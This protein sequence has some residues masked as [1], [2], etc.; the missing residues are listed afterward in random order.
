MFE[1]SDLGR[2]SVSKCSELALHFVR[3]DTSPLHASSQSDADLRPVR[4]AGAR[5]PVERQASDVPDPGNVA[6]KG[7]HDHDRR[8]NWAQLAR[9]SWS[10]FPLSATLPGSGTSL[11]WRSTGARAPASLTGRKSASDWLEAWSGLVSRRTKWSASSLHLD[12]LWRP[13]SDASNNSAEPRL[14]LHQS[15]PGTLGVIPLPGA[16][17]SLIVVNF[18]DAAGAQWSVTVTISTSG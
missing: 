1:A 14:L 10:C 2:H 8:A 5:A 3:R 6:L 9:R 12:T 16:T 11:A 15:N 18:S 13:R 17:A 7:K 4:L